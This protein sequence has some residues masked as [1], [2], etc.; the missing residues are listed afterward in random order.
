MGVVCFLDVIFCGFVS[1]LYLICLCFVWICAD[2]VRL[3]ILELVI[4]ATCN[5]VKLL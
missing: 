4:V 5:S 2:C 3:L 1:G